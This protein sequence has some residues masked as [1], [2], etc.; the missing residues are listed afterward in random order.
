[1][2]SPSAAVLATCV[3]LL[4]LG[5]SFVAPNYSVDYCTTK[6]YGFPFLWRVDHCLCNQGKVVYHPLGVVGNLLVSTVAAAAV[7]AVRRWSRTRRR[8]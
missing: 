8:K 5:V 1:M 7:V 6:G 4:L 3:L 2:K